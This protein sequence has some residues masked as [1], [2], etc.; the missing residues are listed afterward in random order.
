MQ[1][2]V[3]ASYMGATG[4]IPYNMTNDYMFHYILQK[5]F[6][7]KFKLSVVE[8]NHIEL[9]TDEDKAF[10]ID[11]WA[12]LFKAKTWEELKMVAEKNE[13]LN[14]AAKS[15]YVA[16]ADEIVRQK[17]LAREAAERHERTVKRDIKRMT[18]QIA[19]LT[20]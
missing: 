5:I 14:E 1:D 11:Y 9:A 2:T 13:Y 18:K 19:S 8:L 16:N 3:Y 6:S 17:C 20:E 7:S 10:Q 15:V 4:N 12:R